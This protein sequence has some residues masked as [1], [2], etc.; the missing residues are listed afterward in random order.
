MYGDAVLY[1][2]DTTIHKKDFYDLR[3]PDNLEQR[4]MVY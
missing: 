1:S 4:R 2:N 3:T